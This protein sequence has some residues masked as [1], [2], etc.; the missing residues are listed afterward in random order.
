MKGFKLLF[1]ELKKICNVKRT[2]IVIALLFASFYMFSPIKKINK[3]YDYAIGNYKS[4]INMLNEQIYHIQDN[5]VISAEQSRAVMFM[6]KEIEFDKRIIKTIEEENW[7]YYNQIKIEIADYGGQISQNMKTRWG[8]FLNYESDSDYLNYYLEHNIPVDDYGSAADSLMTLFYGVVPMALYIIVLVFGSL[9]LS[10]EYETGSI[11]TTF[12]QP[13]SPFKIMLVKVTAIVIYSVFLVAVSLLIYYLISGFTNWF[14]R[15][16]MPVFVRNR[17]LFRPSD[18][19]TDGNLTMISL[20]GYL[21]LLSVMYIL[22]AFLIA[23]VQVLFSFIF[24]KSVVTLGLGVINVFGI[25]LIFLL[26]RNFVFLNKIAGY[27]PFSYRFISYYLYNSRINSFFKIVFS[28][29]LNYL[30]LQQYD[31]IYGNWSVC[32]FAQNINYTNGILSI[33]VF[34]IL[35]SLLLYFLSKRKELLK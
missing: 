17:R 6:Q 25:P 26:S 34:I 27:Y 33:L 16:D 28:S 5:S 11:K 13:Y 12:T 15:F 19:L 4:L 18:F 7:K 23:L 2:V 29:D 22:L 3:N 32:S 20:G 24:K 14:G 30:G 35:I 8:A 9:S 1:I 10:R 31:G 21:I